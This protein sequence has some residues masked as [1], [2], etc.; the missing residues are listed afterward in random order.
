MNRNALATADGRY[1]GR[2]RL[3]READE[4]RQGERESFA[5]VIYLINTVC[6]Y[7]TFEEQTRQTAGRRGIL[8][9]HLQ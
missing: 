2:R 8:A 7:S 1:G 6:T 5:K 3:E 9:S 4:A